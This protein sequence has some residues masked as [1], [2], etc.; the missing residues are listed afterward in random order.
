MSPM[1]RVALWAGSL[2]IAAAMSAAP[3]DAHPHVFVTATEEVLFAPDG[4]VTG[5]RH[6]WRFD[7]MYSSFVT[8][9]LGPEG[10]V[11]TREQM[12]PL[13]KTNVESL[14]EF[15]FFTVVKA[16]GKQAEF[17][18][19]VDYWLEESS[20]K[21]VTL[22]FT[23]PLKVPA[24]AKPVLSLAVYDPTYFVS[25]NLAEKDPVLLNA[26]PNGCSSSVSKPKAL[27]S[28]D[29]QKLSEAFFSNMSPGVDFGIKLAERA[30]VACP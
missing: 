30:I 12:A 5:I 26:A 21:L 25:F 27:D 22:H 8:Q 2:G 24:M 29:N 28:G 18:A 9:G 11:L 4:Q 10:A 20:D 1:L 19:P 15:G 3:A 14:A 23:L 17:G 6:A 7:D 16:G 13:A